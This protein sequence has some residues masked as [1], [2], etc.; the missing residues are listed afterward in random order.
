MGLLPPIAELHR[1]FIY[2]PDTGVLRH[3]LGQHAGHVA[4][5]PN[6]NG[7][8][9]VDMKG[10]GRRLRAY[11][12]QIAIAMMTGAWPEA[13]DHRNLDKTDNRFE[14]LRECSRAENMRN[15][16][17]RSH[18]RQPYKGVRK[19]RNRWQARIRVDHREIHL[20]SFLTAE[21]AQASYAAAAE[22]FH[23]EFGRAS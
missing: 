7:Y 13:V 8:L 10:D 16:T 2:D 11:V 1:R 9:R 14:N 4:G 23:G 21:E 15:C 20:G 22:K 6:G 18:S 12:H 3:K 17:Q 19:Q 5:Y